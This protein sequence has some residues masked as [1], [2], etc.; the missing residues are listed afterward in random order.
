MTG[1]TFGGASS[2]EDN[3]RPIL[4]VSAVADSFGRSYSRYFLEHLEDHLPGTVHVLFADLSP[5]TGPSYQIIDLLETV[6]AQLGPPGSDAPTI[7]QLL[8]DVCGALDSQAHY[9]AA[10][11][12]ADGP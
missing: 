2:A 11:S 8:S 12:L 9:G 10:G 7:G 3:G 4:R 6:G 1:R 5:G